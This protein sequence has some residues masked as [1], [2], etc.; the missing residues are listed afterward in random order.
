[1]Y[2]CKNYAKNFDAPE[3]ESYKK[4]QIANNVNYLTIENWRRENVNTLVRNIYSEIKKLNPNVVFGISPGGF[5]DAL[6]ANDKYYVDFETWLQKEG[7]IDYLC[8]QLYWSNDHSL[9][10]FNNI[11]DRFLKAA[12]NSD[13]KMYVGIAAYKAGIKS[14]GTA[15]YTKPTVLSD[16]VRYARNTNEVQFKMSCYRCYQRRNHLSYRSIQHFIHTKAILLTIA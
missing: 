13:V 9:Y 5:M 2:S 11:L 12:E 7:Y 3:Y 1:M 6:K 10:P 14:E 8:P 16:M 15:W 4:K